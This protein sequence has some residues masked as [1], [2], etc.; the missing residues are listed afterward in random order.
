M[1]LPLGMHALICSFFQL[2]I[3]CWRIIVCFFFFI[4]VVLSLLINHFM[5]FLLIVN[6]EVHM[7]VSVSSVMKCFPL[8]TI[9]NAHNNIKYDCTCRKSYVR[10]D[11]IGLHTSCLAISMITIKNFG[12][13][14]YSWRP[15][16]RY[17]SWVCDLMIIVFLGPFFQVL[18]FQV[19]QVDI[20]IVSSLLWSESARIYLFIYFFFLLIGTGC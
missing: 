7:S 9:C 3:I 15:W 13:L 19:M 20:S 8:L 17:Y 2:T 4:I 18:K 11:E 16:I 5:M 6:W 10:R 14:K 12:I 1:L